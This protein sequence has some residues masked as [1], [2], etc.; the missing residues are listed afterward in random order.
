MKLKDYKGVK[1]FD[2]IIKTVKDFNKE[3]KLEFIN[4]ES[5]ETEIYDVYD[6]LNAFQIIYEKN[7]DVG[8]FIDSLNITH[9]V[10]PYQ[11]AVVDYYNKSHGKRGGY[12]LKALTKDEH[13]LLAH[14]FIDYFGFVPAKDRH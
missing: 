10:V 9:Y 14:V 2:K 12:L 5:I 7:V 11:D 3:S 1:S 6:I 8:T 4:L 13:K